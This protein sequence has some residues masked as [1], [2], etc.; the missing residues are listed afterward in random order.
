MKHLILAFS[1]TALA[2]CAE[3]PETDQDQKVRDAFEQIRDRKTSPTGECPIESIQPFVGQHVSALETVMLLG[4]VRVIRPG[5]M[6]TMDYLPTRLNI[7][8]DNRDVI[9]R[10]RCG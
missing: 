6:V 10:L 2:A 9:S 4:Q 5:Q 3:T 8:L 1:V 7:D